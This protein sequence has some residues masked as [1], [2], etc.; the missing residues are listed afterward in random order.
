M[1]ATLCPGCATELPAGYP[2]DHV[3]IDRALAGQLTI[4]GDTRNEAIRVAERRGW[5]RADIAAV[6]RCS[7][8]HI[9][10]T[11]GALPPSL[12]V[13]VRRLHH[14][15][16]DDGVIAVALD[17][18]RKTVAAARA[19]LGLPALYGPGGRRTR[20]EVTA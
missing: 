16:K 12:D 5:A 1:T 14:A 20:R 7:H 2:Y 19:R 9:A 15:G 13:Q 11:L 10:D 17:V 3:A 6:L 18:S 4:T 8:S